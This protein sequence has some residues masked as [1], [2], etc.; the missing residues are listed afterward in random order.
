MASK[1]K[2]PGKRLPRYIS[3]STLGI[4]VSAY[5]SGTTPPVTDQAFFD[6][7][8]GSATCASNPDGSRTCV[9][10]VNAPVG[11]DDFRVDLYDAVPSGEADSGKLLGTG[12]ALSQIVSSTS[13]N[14]LSIVIDGVIASLATAPST[15]V[16]I[17]NGTT[18]AFPVA[19]N[20]LDADKNYIVGLDPLANPVSLTLSGDPNQTLSL[21]AKTIATGAGNRVTLTYKSGQLVSGLLTATTS[22][23]I[24][25][26]IPVQGFNVSPTSL[27][28]NS[29]T[30][31]TVTVSDAGYNSVFEAWSSDPTCATVS[32]H[33]ATPAGQG[34]PVPFT[35]TS[36]L[37][38]ACTIQIVGRAGTSIPVSTTLANITLP[39]SPHWL[40]YPRSESLSVS[41]PGFTG[42]FVASVSGSACVKPSPATAAAT[43][44]SA[45]FT[46]AA[47]AAGTCT[48]TVTGNQLHAFSY[49][50]YRDNWIMFGH[51]LNRTGN[52]TDPGV[53]L[54]KST[55]GSLK[56]RWSEFI[57]S[58]VIGQPLVV[59]G[60][61]YVA[62]FNGTVESL[63]AKTGSVIWSIQPFGTA[64][65][66]MSPSYDNGTLFVGQHAPGGATVGFDAIGAETGRIKWS[67]QLP[68]A[69]RGSPA[70][71]NGTVFI[72]TAD[73]DPAPYGTCV[74]G[75]V[76]A[77]N[78]A[79]GAVVWHYVVDQA[80]GDGGSVWSPISFD[81][82][83]LIFGTGNTCSATPVNNQSNSVVALSPQT[84]GVVWVSNILEPQTNDN[85][86][87]AGGALWRGT[88]Y[89]QSK[90]GNFYII[91]AATGLVQAKIPDGLPLYSGACTPVTDG[92]HVIVSSGNRVP[93]T[94]LPTG[95]DGGL[96]YGFDMSGH[97]D[98]E[99]A[100]SA[101]P[102][103]E[104][105]MANGML[106]AG[107]DHQLNALDAS[108]G[109]LLWS[110]PFSKSADHM[111]SPPVVTPSGLY[112]V[113]SDGILLAFGTN[114]T[115]ASAQFDARP[116]VM[117]HPVEQYVPPNVKKALGL[118]LG[119]D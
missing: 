92:K 85:D 3:P 99:V 97:Q 88:Y 28:F 33:I 108:T 95:S 31:Q 76:F 4:G 42:T 52:Q 65:I 35:V 38:G 93:L 87:G 12:Y 17:E 94:L 117:E 24:T 73:G 103:Y 26:S 45:A 39:A 90:N 68:G 11:T 47:V 29:T 110:Y 72:G 107:M 44:G 66:T 34:S 46:I 20:L 86:D 109:A 32:P 74:Q 37:T 62:E 10:S 113:T 56:L 15:I 83:K 61:I 75:G 89:T 106:L 70:V 112:A 104:M 41:E 5:P 84:G 54:T 48:V 64:R 69:I 50:V 111:W 58:S 116:A 2:H 16:P 59:D 7:A 82:S 63:D 118:G 18:Q 96:L 102:V 115:N 71:H 51:D 100:T 114:T 36:S 49:T 9:F 21:S 77:L 22:D 119:D 80:A 101:W 57:G 25:A 19:I 91:N 40:I 81:G 8:P 30:P 105:T 67:V 43:N 79:S 98:W 60:R 23:G 6:A 78:E 53:T 27:N 14:T 13:A 55:V 1:T